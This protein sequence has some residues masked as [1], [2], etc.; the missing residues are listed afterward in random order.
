MH[1]GAPWGTIGA[2]FTIYYFSRGR[3]SHTWKVHNF[4]FVKVKKGRISPRMP[5]PSGSSTKQSKFDILTDKSRKW[6]LKKIVEVAKD[7]GFK[8]ADS[9][10]PILG[11][12]SNNA[13]VWSNDTARESSIERYRTI[14]DAFTDFCIATKDYKSAICTH[15]SSLIRNPCAPRVSTVINFVNYR[16]YNSETTLVDC[17]TK[18]PVKFVGIRGDIK[19]RGDWTSISTLKLLGSSLSKLSEHFKKLE[20]PYDDTCDECVSLH[21]LKSKTSR[22]TCEMHGNVRVLHPRGNLTTSTKYKTAKKRLE[23]YIDQEYVTRSTVAYL[24]SEVRQ[25]RTYLLA[26]NKLED[27]MIWTI[28]ILSIKLFLRIEEALS[29]SIE[30]FETDLATKNKFRVK[31]LLLKV[32]GKRDNK[33]VHLQVY[34]DEEC[35]ELSPVRALMIWL[36]LSGIK[37]GFIFPAEELLRNGS[38]GLCEKHMTYHSYAKKLKFLTINILGRK[39]SKDSEIIVGTHAARRTG[40]L[41]ATWWFFGKSQIENAVLSDAIFVASLSND[42][43]NKVCFGDIRTDMRH[44]G[45]TSTM[46]YMDDS[47]AL[48]LMA[49]SRSTH[50]HNEKVPAYKPIFIKRIQQAKNA[51]RQHQQL[52]MSELANW[53]VFEC[54][55]LDKIG[56]VLDNMTISEVF[57]LADGSNYLDDE[58]LTDSQKFLLNALGRDGLETFLSLQGSENSEESDKKKLSPSTRS[59]KK[60]KVHVDIAPEGSKLVSISELLRKDFKKTS[61]RRKK[62]DV[63]R[64]ILED[65][66]V[67]LKAGRK[68]QVRDEKCVL[69][70]Q[71]YRYGRVVQCVDTCF[72]GDENRFISRFPKFTMRT[73]RCPKGCN[74]KWDFHLGK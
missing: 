73:H 25:L 28:L 13:D 15:P 23:G 48:Y 11:Q 59:T 38:V 63:A 70:T 60:A 74:H 47:P 39:V 51:N 61:D 9:P 19:C 1:H 14:W 31:T 69:F 41:F 57:E 10:L 2:P 6:G 43:R 56:S 8:V 35:P 52:N 26:Q 68:M 36:A 53:Y 24:P 30:S 66:R 67:Q 46:N 7:L 33:Y 71:F 64:A 50:S 21:N 20:G 58:N 16:V 12:T 37:G 34:D 72:R 65:L 55:G 42:A 45:G 4:S 5:K 29:L 22:K 32:K 62:I 18:K 3:K 27:L 17:V 44:V 40:L 49:Q 54:L